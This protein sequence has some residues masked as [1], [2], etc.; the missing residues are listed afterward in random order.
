M[1]ETEIPSI[2]EESQN[3][4][5][6]VPQETLVEQ[7]LQIDQEVDRQEEVADEGSKNQ[8]S[9]G[10]SSAPFQA[11]VKKFQSLT[12][13]EEQIQYAIQFMEEV[14]TFAGGPRF[15]SFWEA[16]QLSLPL[17]KESL[18]SPLRSQLWD[19]YSELSKEARRLKEQLDEQN[20]FAAEQIEIAISALENDLEHLEEQAGRSNL[21]DAF[22]FPGDLE[23][24]TGHY[25][26]LQRKL[27]FLNA[28]ASRINALRKELLKTEMRIKQKN[29]FFQRLSSAGDHVFPKRKELIAQVSEDFMTDVNRF[30]Q[31]HF[32]DSASRESL[33]ILREEIKR[34][35]GLAKV[36]TLN[37]Q[38]FTQ[39][40]LYLSE[41]WDH[42][43][44]EER[45][46]K[47]ERAQQR[48]VHK[49]NFDQVSEQIAAIK[50]AV[51]AGAG[52]ITDHQKSLDSI[53]VQMRKIDLGRDELKILR[54]ALNEIRQHIQLKQRGQE[55]LRQQQEH[56]KLLQKKERV[57]TF[58]ERAEK[59]V[60]H[61]ETFEA[62]ALTQARDQLIHEMQTELSKNE[63]LEIEKIL[64]PLRDII[65]DKR[66]KVVLDLS[67]DDRFAL[68]QLQDILKQRQ[69]RR[70]EIK[71]QLEVLRKAGGSS[72]LDF[73]KAMQYN[74]RMYE[75][76]ERL[77]KTNRGIEEI[78][79]KIKELKAKLKK[80]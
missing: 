34:W 13:P 37:T 49:Q 46:R 48:S 77:E 70:Q 17:F 40:R 39:T 41:C 11:F 75:E 38:V 51:E 9:S 31:H 33:Y 60:E 80:S 58:K 19:R 15:R 4:E 72:S 8:S 50:A 12:L 1:N 59:L 79:H 26:E 28:H 20:A 45:E 69:A 73:E 3:M 5:D 7:T 57:D 71:Q 2:Q 23:E 55:E 25:T 16:R 78:E 67:E 44:V 27:N 22:I 32:K 56:E 18:A 47:K 53:V 10:A 42:I 64:K 65:T 68:N 21:A 74:A 14:L 35:Q 54:E 29:R 30:I 66:E 43:K 63:R 61:H 36:L 6:V 52:T 24:K 62:E 76:K